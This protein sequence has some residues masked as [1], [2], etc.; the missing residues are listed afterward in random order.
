MKI[1]KISK[2][3]MLNG[4]GIRQVLWFSGCCNFCENCHQKYTWDPDLGEDFTQEKIEEVIRLCDNDYTQGITLTGG[5]PFYPKNREA[6]FDFVKQ[7]KERLPEKDI[8]CWT[9]YTIE[10]LIKEPSA[11]PYID[12]M[13]DGKFD[14]DQREEDLKLLNA[15]ELLRYRGSTNQR[16]IDVQKSIRDNA[17][18]LYVPGRI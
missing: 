15:A 16:V 5:D 1:I 9:G 8:W 6:L 18:I 7:F 17:V 11:V 10:E 3:N 13:V 14:K 12:V 2:D 4:P